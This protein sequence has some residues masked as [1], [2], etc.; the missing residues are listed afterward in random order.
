MRNLWPGCLF[1]VTAVLSGTCQAQSPAGSPIDPE[2]PLLADSS[3]IL[4]A[5]MDV[6][7]EK[8]DETIKTG[9]ESFVTLRFDVLDTI[10]GTGGLK[11]VKAVYRS[12]AESYN[13]APKTVLA[14][15][16]KEVLVF[17]SDRYIVQE[18]EAIRLFE[19]G[20]VEQL[21]KEVSNQWLIK[22]NFAQLPAAMPDNLQGTVRALIDEMTDEATQQDAVWRLQRLGPRAAPSIIRLMDDRRTLPLTRTMFI[23]N[24]PK[25]FEAISHYGPKVVVDAL[26]TVLPG[27]TER[28]FGAINSGGSEDERRTVVNAWRVYLHYSTNQS[29]AGAKPSEPPSLK[30]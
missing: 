27:M 9:K 26:A 8:V 14:L 2:W 12:G 22:K 24:H 15:N 16:G 18:K 10:K 7:V 25:A 4:R 5:R 20:K 1:L 13:P 23:N 28:S 3:L 30:R 11:S 17:I 29:K 21:R 19:P 6:P